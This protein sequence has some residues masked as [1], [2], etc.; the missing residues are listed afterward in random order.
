MLARQLKTDTMA[1]KQDNSNVQAS[2]TTNLS[3]DTVQMETPDRE[4]DSHVRGSGDSNSVFVELMRQVS[5]LT[6]D[7]PEA[8]LRFIARLD[9]VHM[10]G[11]CDDRSFVTCILP[12]VPGVMMRFFGECLR[13]QRD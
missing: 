8:I 9:E 1:S 10:L 3:T 5:P 2:V 4:R 11:L 7:E 6:S 12:L 13:N